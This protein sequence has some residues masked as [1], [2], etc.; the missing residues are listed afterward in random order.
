MVQRTVIS[1][2]SKVEYFS[3]GSAAQ[4]KNKYNLVNL[5]THKRDFGSDAEWKFSQLHMESFH[6]MVLEAA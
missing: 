4:Y 3:D 1:S 6:V 5:C 2:A